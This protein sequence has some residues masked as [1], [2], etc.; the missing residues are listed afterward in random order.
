MSCNVM[1]CNVI[2][3]PIDWGKG[4]NS[5]NYNDTVHRAYHGPGSYFVLTFSGS[6]NLCPA[7]IW[8]IKLHQITF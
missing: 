5:D 1:R 8:K 7:I 6:L 2:Y 4:V 3:N